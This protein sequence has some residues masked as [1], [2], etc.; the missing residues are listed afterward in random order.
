MVRW[1]RRFRARIRYR[2]FEGDLQAE[3]ETHR[4]LLQDDL[5][6][7]GADNE[8]ARA[9]A[10]RALGNVTLQREQARGVW[11]APWLESLWQDARYGVRSLRRSPAFSLA[12]LATLTIGLALATMMFTAFSVFA[13]NPWKVAHT[14]GLAQLRLE[15]G[16][17]DRQRGFSLADVEDIAARSRTVSAI[18]AY[19]IVYLRVTPSRAEESDHVAAQYVTPGFFD[20]LELR[21]ALGR[22]FRP[23]ENHAGAANRVAIISHGMWQRRFGGVPDVIGRPIF[24]GNDAYT[25][26]GVAP[27]GWNGPAPYAYELWLPL[28][29]LRDSRPDDDVFSEAAGRCCVSVITRAVP[30]VGPDRVADE[31]TTLL[32]QR[33]QRPDER[34]RRVR[35]ETAT[36]VGGA[37][38][39]LVLPVLVLAATLIILF[40]AS[41]NLAHLQLARSLS[42]AREIQTR[43]A[44]GASRARIVRQL[45]TEALLLSLVAGAASLLLTYTL[46]GVL[47]TVSETRSPE[48][49]TPG[50]A[51]SVFCFATSAL[52]SVFFGL[53][54]ALRSTRVSLV[55]GAGRTA[56]PAGRLAHGLVLLTT[57]IALSLSLVAG[58]SLLTRGIQHA[59]DL[60]VGYPMREV[61]VATV[62]PAGSDEANRAAAPGFMGA[63]ASALASSDLPRVAFADFPPLTVDISTRVHRG[64]ETKRDD[65]SVS[66]VGLSPNGFDVLGIPI[67]EGRAFTAGAGEVVVN[68]RMARLLWPDS[69]ALGQRIIEGDRT[70]TVVGVSRD[71]HYASLDRI[72]PTLHLPTRPGLYPSMLLR[73]HD[74]GA[75]D[76]IRAIVAAI[77]RRAALSITQAS[78]NLTTKL[79]DQ[80]GL[81]LAAWGAGLL[82]LVLAS[83][84]VFG[85]FAYIV[86]ERRREIGI[87]LAL[88][89]ERRQVLGALFRTTR[90][91][92]LGGFTLGLLLSLLAGPLLRQFLYGLSPFDPTAFAIV[93]I[94]LAAAGF[95]ATFIPARR[96][97]A[98]EPM[99]VLKEEG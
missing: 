21:L 12:A 28:E 97:M 89:A 38:A 2:H 40:L 19:R 43:L 60:D 74:A 81:A 75:A 96:A 59:M 31:L 91:A 13:L 26:I 80:R 22:N 69:T 9:A 37:G 79:S 63:L 65:R 64:G 76:R 39:R 23:D 5:A 33:W 25:V 57:Q 77:D 35:A 8:A 30:G 18:G 83:C 17:P 66:V 56:T 4:S 11:L 42:R 49:W 24:H 88:G 27:K 78:D 29:S 41:A 62:R 93:A 55:L 44:L 92:I 99:I 84:G 98:V 36:F 95:I 61:M 52:M 73:S 85:V 53:A 67:V 45:L 14:R 58:A 16:P 54:P 7:S 50:P 10:A 51:V 72:E 94:V 82:G 48:L 46:S 87:R 32:R 1:L 20:A 47:M 34:D 3:I 70:Y 15:G 90:L 71:V 6:R 68:Q 86:E